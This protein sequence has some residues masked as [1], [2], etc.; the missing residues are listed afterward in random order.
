S[1]WRWSSLFMLPSPGHYKVGTPNDRISELN[2]WPACTPVNASPATLRPPAHDSGP[3]WVASPFLYGSCIR[4][5]SPVYPA[6]SKVSDVR[7]VAAG[8]PPLKAGWGDRSGG[9]RS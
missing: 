4:Y 8:L 5:Y 7:T 2:G 9:P 6:L 1:G 3:G